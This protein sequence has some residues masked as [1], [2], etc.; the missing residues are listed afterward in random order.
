[1][2]WPLLSCCAISFSSCGSIDFDI[3]IRSGRVATESRGAHW[4][5]TCSRESQKALRAS[6]S[7][8]LPD[9]EARS[10]PWLPNGSGDGVPWPRASPLS[11][12][13]ARCPSRNRPPK[14]PIA[15]LLHGPLRS[16]THSRV[17][18]LGRAGGGSDQPSLDKVLTVSGLLCDHYKLIIRGQLN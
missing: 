16:S 1:M 3:P 12:P 4:T 10:N 14:C 17:A 18:P 11:T 15:F 6:S 2:L 8:I 7:S 9:H 13:R 5:R